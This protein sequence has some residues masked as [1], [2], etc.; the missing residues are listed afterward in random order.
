MFI[1]TG[2]ASSINDN[3]LLATIVMLDKCW[4]LRSYVQELFALILRLCTA[5]LPIAQESLRTSWAMWS[6]RCRS[7]DTKELVNIADELAT[8]PNSAATIVSHNKVN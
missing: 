5:L 7:S 1:A 4:R 6:S 3:N 2:W 8:L